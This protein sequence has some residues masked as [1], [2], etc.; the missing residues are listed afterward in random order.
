MKIIDINRF[1]H[2]DK[3]ILYFISYIIL[4]RYIHSA[5]YDRLLHT[6]CKLNDVMQATN[7]EWIVDIDINT[8]IIY[9]EDFIPTF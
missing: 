1:T 2:W 4:V 3:S 9:L 7:Y 6:Y 5:S 8:I